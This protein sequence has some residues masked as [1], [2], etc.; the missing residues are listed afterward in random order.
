VRW[1]AHS[2]ARACLQEPLENLEGTADR[3]IEDY[4]A[5]HPQTCGFDCLEGESRN[6]HDLSNEFSSAVTSFYQSP[7]LEAYLAVTASRPSTLSQRQLYD[8]AFRWLRKAAVVA[9]AEAERKFQRDS[10]KPCGHRA[11]HSA[12]VRSRHL[13]CRRCDATMQ[14]GERLRPQVLPGHG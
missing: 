12:I 3:A 4:Y 11:R 9:V 5:T 8:D 6:E 14:G 7:S 1:V 10:S 2:P 13:N